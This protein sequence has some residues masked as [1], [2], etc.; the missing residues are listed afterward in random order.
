MNHYYFKPLRFKGLSVAAANLDYQDYYS[1]IKKPV[2]LCTKIL[3]MVYININKFILI[4]NILSEFSFFLSYHY[5]L[6]KKP[7]A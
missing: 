1:Y 6:N 7:F 5:F 3:I 2:L 4:I